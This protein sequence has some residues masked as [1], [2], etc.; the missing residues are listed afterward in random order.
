ME[1]KFAYKCNNCNFIY[2][3]GVPELCEKCG[4]EIATKNNARCL[5]GLPPMEVKNTLTKIK[6]YKKWWQL[7]WT[8]LK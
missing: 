6:V 5:L 4:V 8:E 7:K 2:A 1:Y 3:N